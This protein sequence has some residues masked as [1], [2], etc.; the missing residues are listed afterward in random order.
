MKN[1]LIAEPN[2]NG[3]SLDDILQEMKQFIDERLVRSD[4]H[5]AI[6]QAHPGSNFISAPGH[7]LRSPIGRYASLRFLTPEEMM[8]SATILLCCATRFEGDM[9]RS[10]FKKHHNIDM[11]D[12]DVRQH[13]MAFTPNFNR[14]VA[15]GEAS[16]RGH[17]P[18][19]G[20]TK[21]L[22]NKLPGLNMAF[23]T[24]SCAAAMDMG[25]IVVSARGQDGLVCRDPCAEEDWKVAPGFPSEA[26]IQASHQCQ[27]EG[28]VT[29][30]SPVQTGAKYITEPAAFPYEWEFGAFLSALSRSGFIRAG[31]EV[32]QVSVVV[33]N[34]GIPDLASLSAPDALGNLIMFWKIFF[35]TL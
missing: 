27:K 4:V 20:M 16:D 3:L 7:K 30:R 6:M 29:R 13:T 1:T 28:L 18:M 15:I 34:F 33:H 5:E 35:E 19:Y 23:K 8:E 12:C 31:N 11:T 10:M 24:G 17:D 2:T 26:M 22:V 21:S 9:I 25:T 32:G 14:I